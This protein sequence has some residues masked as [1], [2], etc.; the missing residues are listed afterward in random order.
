MES[1][2]GE[3][4]SNVASG[5]EGDAEKPSEGSGSV[6]LPRVEEWRIQI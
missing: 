3:E 4:L 2:E 1:K 5:G 6:S